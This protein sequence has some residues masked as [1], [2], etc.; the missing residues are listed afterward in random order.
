MITRIHQS[1]PQIHRSDPQ[2]HQSDPQIHQ[3]D[4]QIHQHGEVL[5]KHLEWKLLTSG[6]LHLC[7]FSSKRCCPGV[8][9]L[10]ETD[11]GRQRVPGN[12]GNSQVCLVREAD[13][14]DGHFAASM[15]PDGTITWSCPGNELPAPPKWFQT[16][17]SAQVK[18]SFVGG[19][20]TGQQTISFLNDWQPR[21][22]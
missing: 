8:F 10:R 17:L 20:M 3:S 2:I 9:L 19:W 6:S 15:Q 1:D 11:G 7:Y 18:K 21:E 22:R 16:R 14:T 5:P 13:K 4:P 12:S